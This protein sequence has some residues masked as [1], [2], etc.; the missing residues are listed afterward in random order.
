[1]RCTAAGLE[2]LR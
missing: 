2:E 1:L